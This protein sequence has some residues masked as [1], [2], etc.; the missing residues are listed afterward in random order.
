MAQLSNNGSHHQNH[1]HKDWLAQ[2]IAQ[3][4]EAMAS[5]ESTPTRNHRDQHENGD[6][7]Q[8]QREE[9]G[10]NPDPP[11]KNS[12]DSLLVEG[13][14]NNKKIKELY[15]YMKSKYDWTCPETEAIHLS[16]R[17]NPN[18]EG[19]L[20]WCILDFM[21]QAIEQDLTDGDLFLY[22]QTK[23]DIAE[24]GTFKKVEKQLLLQLVSF[25]RLNG[26]YI[27]KRSKPHYITEKLFKLVEAIEEPEWPEREIT[28]VET[29][30]VGP[31]EVWNS[32]LNSIY[33]RFIYKYGGPPTILQQQGD[34][35][36]GSNFPE[37]TF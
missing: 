36:E 21:V 7:M 5:V 17:V 22:Y 4:A 31:G 23:F 15:K 35:P 18:L 6:K 2:Q 29:H 14:P 10:S 24:W 19:N 9:I 27:P 25:L 1:S 11:P 20:H 32:H 37:L 13:N 34:I 30:E 8:E 28:L 33:H 16:E 26:V 3:G 12:R